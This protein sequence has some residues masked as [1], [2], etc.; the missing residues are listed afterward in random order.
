M[1]ARF[2]E[3]VVDKSRSFNYLGT[4]QAVFFPKVQGSNHMFCKNVGTDK[5]ELARTIF[6]IK[7]SEECF[8]IFWDLNRFS[9]YTKDSDRRILRGTARFDD[10]GKRRHKQMVSLWLPSN[11]TLLPGL[12]SGHS[13]LLGP[14]STEVQQQGTLV[15][16]EGGGTERKIPITVQISPRFFQISTVHEGTLYPDLLPHN[17]Y[18]WMIS[19]WES[20]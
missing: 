14:A 19:G 20:N 3:S 15:I 13:V 9:I 18:G 8:Q 10:G 17:S 12:T 6:G 1:D 4:I 2:P 11:Q 16:P 7:D 5:F